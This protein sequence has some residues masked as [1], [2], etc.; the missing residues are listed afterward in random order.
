[1]KL[2]NLISGPRNI[3]TA[4]MYAFA[5][6]PDTSVWD[7]PFYAC[8]LQHAGVD[9]PGKAEVMRAQSANPEVVIRLLE[10]SKKPLCFVK[11]M[12]HHLAYVPHT[13]NAHALNVFLIRD[14]SHILAS[15]A[16]VIA[17]PT[18]DDIGIAYQFNLFHK[19]SSQGRRPVVV[20]S[21]LLLE[22]P[23]VVI[24]KLCVL[25]DIPS[26]GE[27]LRWP[28]GPK[29]YDGIWAKYWYENVHRSTGFQRQATSSRPLPD[30]LKMLDN[31]AQYY[32]AQLLPYSLRA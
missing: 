23:E 3:S 17:A 6:R 28:A 14:P 7:E 2:I 5:Q 27:M 19:L 22:N 26:Y 15:Y 32:Y 8:Y 4:L 21:G 18:L 20:D 11:N 13:F 29:P 9:H 25:L 30:D 24:T 12:A 10:D 31:E 1:M 16:Q